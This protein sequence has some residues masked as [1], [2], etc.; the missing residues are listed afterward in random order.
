M[1]REDSKIFPP[2]SW[3][4]S[5]QN[6]LAVV[7]QANKIQDPKWFKVLCIQTQLGKFLQNHQILGTSA[8]L[9]QCSESWFLMLGLT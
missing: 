7:W 3:I 2:K 6:W 5:V 9:G 1:V 8:P 4:L